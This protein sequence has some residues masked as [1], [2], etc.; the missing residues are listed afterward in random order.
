MLLEEG[1]K[2]GVLAVNI[3]NLMNAV[4]FG[5]LSVSTLVGGIAGHTASLEDMNGYLLQCSAFKSI[6]ANCRHLTTHAHTRCDGRIVDF[7]PCKIGDCGLLVRCL[8]YCYVLFFIILRLV[9]I[10]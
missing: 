1:Y 4:L 2:F 3:D 5:S 8:F 10:L 7:T 9:R 6:C